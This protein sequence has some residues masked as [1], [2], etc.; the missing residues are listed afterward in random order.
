MA[1]GVPH[2]RALA[3]QVDEV[4][5][6]ARGRVLILG[7]IDAGADDLGPAVTKVVRLVDPDRDERTIAGCFDTVISVGALS[8]IGDLAGFLAGLVPHVH[9]DGVLVFC[10]PTVISDAVVDHP[11]HDITGTLWAGDW[12]VIECRRFRVGRGRRAQEYC[13]GR[14]RLTRFVGP[15]RR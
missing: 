3:T 13:W 5:A 11:P 10:E 12:S 9:R 6:R 14:A 2:D 15:R 8:A 7:S 4:V 1:S